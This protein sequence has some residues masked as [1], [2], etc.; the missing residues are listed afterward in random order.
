MDDEDEIDNELEAQDD[1]IL[2]SEYEQS[3]NS[4]EKGAE[5]HILNKRP[6]GIKYDG[7][8]QTHLV[9]CKR[10]KS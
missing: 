7:S 3:L 4:Y 10:A 6:H 2:R 9:C 8:L 1:D 5:T